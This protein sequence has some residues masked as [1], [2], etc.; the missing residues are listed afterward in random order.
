MRLSLVALT[1]F[2]PTIT[3]ALLVVPTSP[4]CAE[5]CGNTLDGT[6]GS[7]ITCNDGDY[8]SSAYGASFKACIAC[9]LQSTYFDPNSRQ[10][11]LQAAIYNLRFALA[12]CMFGW[13]NNTHGVNTPCS[14]SFSCGPLQK[15]FVYDSL[16]PNASS[17][18]YCPM[19]DTTQAPKCSEC[20]METGYTSFLGNFV[21]AL[22]AACIQQPLP[23]ATISI[24]GSVFS[25]SRVNITTATPS[26][27]SHFN[28]STGGLTLGGKIGIAVGGVIILL[29]TTGFC[30]VWRGKRRRRRILAEKARQSGYEWQA[31]HGTT[32]ERGDVPGNAGQFFDSPQ[33]QRPF[34]TA[35][36]YPNY[37]PESANPEKAYFSPYQSHHTSPVTPIVGLSKPTDWPKDRASPNP[38]A[39]GERIEMVG[40][41]SPNS[42][43]GSWQSNPAPVLSHPGN[44]R[45]APTGLGLTEEDA[46][47]GYAL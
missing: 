24:D 5:L 46:K 2:V 33:S 18:S 7:E 37:S 32:L 3:Q 40:V 29:V 9:E 26:A 36:G 13:E 8:S 45:G 15:S 41:G 12:W 47:L 35:W 38:E 20:L 6:S 44:G 43:P 10:S 14:T 17:Y 30:I 23:N 19:F 34:A 42:N 27:L 22:D 1:V 16:N 31:K 4:Q 28:P 25:N 11:D 39:E 21:T